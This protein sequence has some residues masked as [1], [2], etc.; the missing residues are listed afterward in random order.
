MV[1]VSDKLVKCL[2]PKAILC[3][4]PLFPGG[5][6]NKTTRSEQFPACLVC[7]VNTTEELMQVKPVEGI[8]DKDLQGIFPQA[9]FTLCGIDNNAHACSAMERLEVEQIYASCC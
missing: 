6:M 2:V 3:A 9:F 8:M 5:S 7:G 4:V 1:I